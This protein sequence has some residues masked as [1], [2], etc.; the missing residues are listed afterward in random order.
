MAAQSID[1]RSTRHRDFGP[2]GLGASGT[3]PIAKIAV[4]MPVG[5]GWAE[6]DGYQVVTLG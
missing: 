1:P 6:H 4:D 2:A 5:A 3:E